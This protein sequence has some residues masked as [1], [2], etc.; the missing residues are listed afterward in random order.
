[1]ELFSNLKRLRY[2][3]LFWLQLCAIKTVIAQPHRFAPKFILPSKQSPYPLFSLSHSSILCFPCHILP[4]FVFLVTFLHPLFSL[5]YTRILCFPCRI[6]V[7]FVFLFT[8]FHP[9]FSLSPILCQII[10]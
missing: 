10:T 4:S 1:M 6:L 9:L 2:G 8:F 7:S 5:S 3:K